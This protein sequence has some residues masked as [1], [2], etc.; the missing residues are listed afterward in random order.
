MVSDTFRMN[1]TSK[2]IE[3]VPITQKFNALSD[4]TRYNPRACDLRDVL[5]EQLFRCYRTK[6][7]TPSLLAGDA[8]C[9]SK[10]SSLG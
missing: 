8:G 4:K 10:M 3:H 1:L 6:I 5:M 7:C 9:Y 2:R